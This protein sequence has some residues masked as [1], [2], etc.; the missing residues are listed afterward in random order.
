MK[1]FRK[2]IQNSDLVNILLA[3]DKERKEYFITMLSSF[4]Y[5]LSGEEVS[6][7]ETEA[8]D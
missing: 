5:V 6:R 7:E 3:F 2:K 1:S 8:T 4:T